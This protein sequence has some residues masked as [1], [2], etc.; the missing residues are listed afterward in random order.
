M[1]PIYTL[2]SNCIG[3]TASD[4]NWPRGDPS[5]SERLPG[6]FTSVYASYVNLKNVE[7][8]YTLIYVKEHVHY[9]F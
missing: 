9:C 7:V 1:A 5:P 8:L 2:I 6:A 3:N 4:E